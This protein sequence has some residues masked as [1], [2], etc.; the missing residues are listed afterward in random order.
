[1]SAP[2]WG[3]RAAPVDRNRVARIVFA[4]AESMGIR[5]R[6][7]VEHL[8]TQVI[9]RL[10]KAQA[11]YLPTLPGMEDLVDRHAR[12]QL[13]P[14]RMPTE[15]EIEAMVMEVLNTQKPAPEGEV[16]ASMKSETEVQTSR[17][18]VAAALTATALQVL[19]KRYLKKDKQ[20]NVIEKPEEM[21]R[22]VAATI[23]AA[24]LNL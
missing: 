16:K 7:L 20:G 19:E 9:E 22:R 3:K 4:N 1:M 5:D 17:E 8:T 23:A 21:F 24:E 13:F 11:A 10:E 18:P 6:K 2:Q 15:A 14:G 12:R